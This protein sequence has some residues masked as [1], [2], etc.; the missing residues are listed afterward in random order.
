MS[1]IIKSIIDL[2]FPQQIL[3]IQ[4]IGMD[5]SFLFGLEKI[6][7]EK[8]EILKK[9][10]SE[11]NLIQLLLD[12]IEKRIKEISISVITLEQELKQGIQEDKR[13]SL[14]VMK[15]Q[16]LKEKDIA[17]KKIHIL[18]N[19]N[20]EAVFFK[21]EMEEMIQTF[22]KKFNEE[23]LSLKNEIE[24]LNLEIQRVN[25]KKE[26]EIRK[27]TEQETKILN[28]R[29]DIQ[30]KKI[31]REHMEWKMKVENEYMEKFDK[32][33][34]A[35]ERF[36]AIK[37]EITEKKEQFREDFIKGLKKEI[38]E[39]KD[40]NNE[41][42][43]F[44]QNL[45]GKIQPMEEKFK[46][47]EVMKKELD[48]EKEKFRMDKEVLELQLNEQK[49]S[50]LECINLLK[51]YKE[52][53]RNLEEKLNLLYEENERIKMEKEEVFK[54]YN[55]SRKDHDQE[56][57]KLK[58]EFSEKE[59]NFKDE[60]EKQTAKMKKELEEGEMNIHLLLEK[61]KEQENIRKKLHNQIMEL[62]G[63]IRVM[64]R[65]RPKIKGEE[66]EINDHLKFPIDSDSDIE[67]VDSGKY[68]KFSFNRVFNEKEHQKDVFSEI[69]Q[70]VQSAIDGYKVCIFAY[71]QTGS[72]KTY[73]MTGTDDNKGIIYLSVQKLY[74]TFQELSN[75]GWTFKVNAMMMEIYNDS[76]NDLLNPDKDLKYDIKEKE[77]FTEITNMTE[78]S[79]ESSQELMKY[80]E[81]AAKNRSK[82]YTKCNEK[83]SRSHSIFNLKLIGENE[84]LGQ[85]TFGVL[86]FVD[87]AG[88]ERLKE[89][90]AIGKRLEETKYI[91][92]SLSAL[93]DVISA[94]SNKEKF[95]PFRNSK[96]TFM[97]K[98]YLGKDSKTLMFV[99]VSPLAKNS[100]ETLCSLR[101]ASKVNS[102]ELGQAKRIQF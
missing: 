20:Q 9:I 26:K 36:Y 76:I 19:Y 97:L 65:V 49:N 78:I 28:E 54:I 5:D 57:E 53:E 70:F 62:K 3:N 94:I 7:K 91:N 89:S 4:D 56:I 35:F 33:I 10:E 29:Y 31:Q 18:K 17:L 22:E 96:L 59:K 63:N 30:V 23:K 69:S 88:S 72:G 50:N 34:A 13:N 48:V 67:L 93:G 80:L 100:S 92:K 39:L 64:C 66:K 21:K 77:N 43:S 6:Q 25:E 32:E 102:C 52:N 51:S 79:V 11:E 85:K 15:D 55:Q 38:S 42:Q 101:F 75:V 8:N 24:T 41:L 1:Y 99:N 81:I 60:I 90:E 16:L 2:F 14:N 71:G 73:T 37:D 45:E 44:I 58:N 86:N 83:S 12:I 68:H 47:D 87:L 46:H 95:I 98:N 74:E 84:K 82:G 40:M 27:W 61:R